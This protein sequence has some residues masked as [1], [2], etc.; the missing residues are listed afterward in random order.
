LCGDGGRTRS[1]TMPLFFRIAEVQ[2]VISGLNLHYGVDAN[3][4]VVALLS[5]CEAAAGGQRAAKLDLWTWFKV[6]SRSRPAHAFHHYQQ[7]H[8]TTTPP[9][10]GQLHDALLTVL[11]ARA[12]WS[13]F[14]VWVEFGLEDVWIWSCIVMTW[15]CTASPRSRWPTRIAIA[16]MDAPQSSKMVPWCGLIL[17]CRARGMAKQLPRRSLCT[18]PAEAQ[19]TGRDRYTHSRRRLKQVLDLV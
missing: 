1:P 6:Q 10:R 16:S 14:C 11:G 18:A 15:S 4:V 9:Q 12:L 7:H 3:R 19:P 17:W 8:T 5:S 2:G 13:R